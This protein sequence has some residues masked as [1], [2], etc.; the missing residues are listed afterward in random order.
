MDRV[1]GVAYVDISER[2]ERHLAEQWVSHLG[3]K[4]LVTFHSTDLRRKSV[5]HTNVMMAIGT[6]VAIVCAESVADE[7]E[8]R[9]LLARLG[10][11]HEVVQISLQQMDS[12]CG[13]ALELE[14][15]RGLPVMAMSTQAYNAFTED[16]RRVMRRHVADIVHAPID[17][18]ERV[19]GGGVR[20]TLAELF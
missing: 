2:A 1:N 11:T 3:Y 7:K 19:G 9:H 17:T 6:D 5:Y 10:H 16:Q 13:N 15:G 14:D 4:D 8:R 12:L 18:L 20:C